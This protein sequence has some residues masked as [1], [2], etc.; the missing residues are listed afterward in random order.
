M[1]VHCPHCKNPIE[2]VDEPPPGEITCAG[3]GSSFRLDELATTAWDQFTGKRFGKF[4]VIGTVGRGAF[5]TVLKARD[6]ELDRTVALK[7]PRAGNVGHGP[8]D[9]DRFLREA[10]SVAQLRF[11]S[12]ITIHEVGSE[13]GTPYLVCDFVEGVTLA[14]LLTSRRPTF[15]E[16][17]KLMAEVAEALH[18]AHCLGVVHRD[19][20]PSNIM[21][22]PDGSPCL[23]DFGLAKR[24]GGEITMTIDGQVLGTPA[25]MSP[26][27]A[28]GEGHRVDGKSDVYSMGVILY[29][30]VTGEL[31]FRGNARMLLHQVLHDEPKPPRRLNDRIPRD[32]ETSA[33]KAMAKEPGRRYA[34]AKTLAE[35]L[36]RF[37]AGEAI[38]ARPVG[39]CEKTAKWV[40]RNPVVAGLVATVLL[41]LMAGTIVSVYFAIGAE[42]Q[43]QQARSK[44]ADAIA[45][46]GELQKTNEELLKA[47]E[48]LNR[49]V[50]AS[51]LRDIGI[52]MHMYHDTYKRLPA[53]AI[54]STDG[55]A[56]LSWRVA[57][58]PFLEQMAKPR[59]RQ[60]DEE[61][62]SVYKQFRLDEP[63]DSAHN[64]KLLEKM[65]AVYAPVTVKT[66]EPH[67][68]FYQV[69]TGKST[70]FEGNKALRLTSIIRGTS[71][72]IM[73]VEASE[74]VP[75]TKP[76]D[77]PYDENK[78]LPKLGLF[79][80]GFNVLL[81]DGDVRFVSR[82]FSEPILRQAITL[83]DI[84]P[85]DWDQLD[86]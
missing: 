32:L 58:L 54:Y 43:A 61:K 37:L 64:K 49:V 67:S 80:R 21:I 27:Q 30:L 72:T 46:K 2:V 39:R 85:F 35:D 36:R 41:V 44:E 48:E 83:D 14:D 22:R 18:Y 10:R 17:A 24:D 62:E 20:K 55:K 76:M 23:M 66:K 11:P 28:R 3:C 68:T 50:G 57:I 19:V 33:L 75:W 1:H 77:L 25:Y 13:N 81:A 52:A 40:R 8:Q 16:S 56:L 7:I 31:P 86:R 47:N 60:L 42:Q 5:G 26:E 15:Q 82:N 74:A 65:P 51:K 29:Q 6:T 59:G 63:W 79:D 73:A 78:P 53:A 84:H 4:E 34:S 70:I 69:F 71:N 38:S 9:L 12:I 45:A